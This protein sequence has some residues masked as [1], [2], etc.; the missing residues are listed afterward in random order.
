M[1]PKKERGLVVFHQPSKEE[2]IRVGPAH[3]HAPQG[4]DPRSQD[5]KPRIKEQAK[6]KGWVPPT[7]SSLFKFFLE[8]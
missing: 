8:I 5:H 7:C 2:K 6:K 1:L 3:K 4:Q